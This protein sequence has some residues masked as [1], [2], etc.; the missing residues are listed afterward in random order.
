MR[1]H[2]SNRIVT[3]ILIYMM[4]QGVVFAIT[5]AG[6]FSILVPVGITPP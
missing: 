4:A 5:T 2:M 3:A 6:R 1:N